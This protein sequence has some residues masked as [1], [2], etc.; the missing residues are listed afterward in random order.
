VI[1]VRLAVN[2][3]NNNNLQFGIILNSEAS[4]LREFLSDFWHDGQLFL[5]FFGN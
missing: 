1:C 2:N 4:V 3:N 5:R